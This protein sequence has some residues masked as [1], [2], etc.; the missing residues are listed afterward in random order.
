MAPRRSMA[1]DLLEL[2]LRLSWKQCLVLAALVAVGLQVVAHLVVP[3][4]PVGGVGALGWFIGRQFA[5]T[6]AR[7]SSYVIPPILVIAAAVSAFRARQAVTLYEGSRTGGSQAVASLTWAEF[8]RLVGEWFR[9]QGYEVQETGG[10]AP[11]GGVDL[12]LRQGSDRYLVQC[13]HWKVE[14][15]GASVVRE[16]NGVVAARKAA[17]GF[18]VTSGAFTAEA[19]AFAKAC[20]VTLV[21]GKALRASIGRAEV[22]GSSPQ[23]AIQAVAS[24]SCPKCGSSM[25]RRVAKQGA[26]AGREFW[27]CSGYPKCRGTHA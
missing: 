11:D 23:A 22:P 20:S 5:G 10:A 4:G 16:L 9:R 17:G 15:V 13:K 3:T 7:L 8:E 24:P 19:E 18:V 14:R 6:A 26:Y 21:D 2:G 12:V 27:G 25:V 1:D